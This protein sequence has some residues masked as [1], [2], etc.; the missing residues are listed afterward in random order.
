MQ[1]IREKSI[2]KSNPVVPVRNVSAEVSASGIPLK[3]C[4]MLGLE[5]VQRD[6]IVL[7]DVNEFD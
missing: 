6:N 1:I 5:L 2:Q 4:H 3:V 7:L